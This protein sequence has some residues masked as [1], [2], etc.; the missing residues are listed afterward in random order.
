MQHKFDV[1]CN[2]TLLQLTGV[3]GDVGERVGFALFKRKG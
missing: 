2:H 3:G 1:M